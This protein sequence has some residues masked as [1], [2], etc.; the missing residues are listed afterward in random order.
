[1][2]WL[3]INVPCPNSSRV[4]DIVLIVVVSIT[5]H[6]PADLDKGITNIMPSARL[7]AFFEQLDH[8]THIA[9]EATVARRSGE[10][11]AQPYDSF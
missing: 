3:R 5:G 1:M 7:Q 11:A 6:E 8:T 9:D 4:I 10:R 2:A